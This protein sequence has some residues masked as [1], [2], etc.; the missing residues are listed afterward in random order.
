MGEWDHFRV[1]RLSSILVGMRDPERGPAPGAG[2]RVMGWWLLAPV[3]VAA[4][5]AGTHAQQPPPG[6]P[7]AGARASLAKA[8]PA[9]PEGAPVTFLPA[10]TARSLALAAISVTSADRVLTNGA[11]LAGKAVP[12]PIDPAGVRDMLLTQAGLSPDVAANLDLASPSG[13]A[14]VALGGGGQSGVVI[15]VAARGPAEAERVIGALG[16][17]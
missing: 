10:A 3:A 1:P 13:A 9:V 2:G 5:C 11:Q 7:A 14:V 6:Q 4:A 12:L 17:V 16:K 8:P 15:A